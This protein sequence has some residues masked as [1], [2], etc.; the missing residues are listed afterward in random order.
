M[1]CASLRA[2]LW[3]RI[4]GDAA[5]VPTA[6]MFASQAQS[7]SGIRRDG[8]SGRNPHGSARSKRRKNLQENCT[9]YDMN[10]R[11]SFLN[12][13]RTLRRRPP[14]SKELRCDP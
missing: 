3:A 9:V 2:T 7:I 5:T 11:F 1:P 13:R 8:R 6:R 4:D 10:V 14:E 12:R